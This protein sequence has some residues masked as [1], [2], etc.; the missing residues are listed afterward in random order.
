M[1]K[2]N[3][4][5]AII[6]G[7]GAA[8]SYGIT[9]IALPLVIFHYIPASPYFVVEPE[10]RFWIIAIGMVVMAFAF[11]RATS[12][13]RSIRRVIFNTFLTFANAFY[14]YSYWLSG[15]ANIDLSDIAIP[16]PDLGNI[17]LGFHL[18]LG[19]IMA[20]ELGVIGLKFLIIAYDLV[21]AIIYLSNRKTNIKISPGE[22]ESDT[23]ATYLEDGGK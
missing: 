19:P 20:L 21:D 17:L 18:N 22:A 15:V 5:N 11:G 8:I 23:L 4:W 1:T 9:I 10:M 7:I 16:I 2:N 13:N 12:P 14:I 3:P 6:R